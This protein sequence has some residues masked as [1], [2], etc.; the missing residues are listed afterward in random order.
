LLTSFLSILPRAWPSPELHGL[1]FGATVDPNARSGGRRLHRRLDCP[2]PR[3]GAGDE[4]RRHRLAGGDRQPDDGAGEIVD[5]QPF[6][7]L[8]GVD[9]TVF[10]GDVSTA[11]RF[12]R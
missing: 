1:Q 12:C 4:T 3:T 2:A 10:P 6:L 7:A 8:P 5:R 11:E 9:Q